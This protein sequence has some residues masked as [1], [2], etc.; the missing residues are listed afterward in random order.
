MA[1]IF[2]DD[3]NSYTDGDLNGQ[4]GWSG[5]TAYDVQGTIVKEGAKAVEC[6]SVVNVGIYKDGT[7]RNDGRITA[8]LRRNT[9][10]SGRSYLTI[11]E[12]TTI[13]ANVRFMDDGN[14]QVHRNGAW[15]TYLA[16]SADIW[17]CIEIE[18]RSSDHKVRYRVNGGAWTDWGTAT[19]E[20]VTGL[21]RVRFDVWDQSAGD[22]GYWD[23]VAEYPMPPV[24]G[25]SFGYIFSKIYE[26][27]KD[28]ASRIFRI[29]AL[30]NP[31]NLAP[32]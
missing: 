1:T 12:G 18:W 21:D 17:Y 31:N 15:E 19:N 4:G 20:W 3:F 25:R 30:V 7:P 32:G 24:V 6:G 22:V 14:L 26:H 16:Y 13:C 9:N 27:T 29:P 2:E 23:Y 10:S 5:D 8:Y 11:K 28:L